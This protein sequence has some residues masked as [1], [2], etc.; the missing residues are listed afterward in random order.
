MP[1]SWLK[2]KI[3]DILQSKNIPQIF[4]FLFYL[5]M[6]NPRLLCKKTMFNIRPLLEIE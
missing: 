2:F 3:M 6:E 4:L 1:L 5:S